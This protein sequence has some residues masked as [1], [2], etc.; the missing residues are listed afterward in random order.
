VPLI[1]FPVPTKQDDRDPFVIGLDTA[2]SLLNVRSHRERI[3]RGPGNALFGPGDGGSGTPVGRP[4]SFFQDRGLGVV[5]MATSDALYKK[6]G[7]GAAGWTAVAGSGAF[8]TSTRGV[9]AATLGQVFMVDGTFTDV[10]FYDGATFNSLVSAGY[11]PTGITTLGSYFIIAFNERVVLVRT[12]ENGTDMLTRLRWHINSD[13]TDWDGEGSGFLDSVENNQDPLTG[14]CVLGDRAFLFKRNQIIELIATGTTFPVFR[15]ESRVQ[16]TGSFA[17]YS[18]A[19]TDEFGFFL[20]NDNIYMMSGGGIQAVGDPIYKT[21]AQK[22][23]TPSIGKGFS[24]WPQG[25]ISPTDSEYWLFEEFTGTSP[26]VFIYDYKRDRWFTEYYEDLHAIGYFR[27]T[28]D[29]AVLNTGATPSST[30]DAQEGF[31]VQGVQAGASGT[32][33][34]VYWSGPSLT[35]RTFNGT[36]FLSEV[37]TR[38]FGA[39]AFEGRD[40]GGTGTTRSAIDRSNICHELQFRGYPSTAYA[41]AASVDGGSTW[42]EEQ[43][44][45]A[46]SNGIVRAFFLVNF[47]RIRFRI[48]GQQL[49]GAADSRTFENHS[50]PFWIEQQLGLRWMEAGF[51]IGGDSEFATI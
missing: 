32:N 43:E 17:P 35:T 9:F 20:G 6:A 30:Q 16:G 40:A 2:T 21:W 29:L 24:P 42:L 38:D 14:A 1:T 50:D 37:I 34:M 49:T 51:E 10:A 22:Q 31:V 48:R 11:L 5:L 33:S 39:S 15:E 27:Q 3:I 4:R 23:I 44:V 7:T 18:W 36:A 46:N 28:G 19:S 25:V 26:N 47:T 13:Y 12:N 41:I 45:T 8:S